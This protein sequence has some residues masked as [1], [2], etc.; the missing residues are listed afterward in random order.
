MKI[1]MLYNEMYMSYL[2]YILHILNT[3]HC[4]V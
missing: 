3:V 1:I 4:I 2:Q